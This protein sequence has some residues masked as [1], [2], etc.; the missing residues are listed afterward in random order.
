MAT[1]HQQMQMFI[2]QHN[3]QRRQYDTELEALYYAQKQAN[4]TEDHLEEA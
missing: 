3:E 2:Q 1:L 4:M